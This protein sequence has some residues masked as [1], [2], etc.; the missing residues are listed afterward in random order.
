MS[1]IT[2]DFAQLLAIEKIGVTTY[3]SRNLPL[4]FGN[5]VPIS[6]G[7]FLLGVAVNVASQTIPSEFHV[8][9]V[10]GCFLAAATITTQLICS[11]ESVRDTKSFLTREVRVSQAERDGKQR[12]CQIVL[13]DFHRRE[14][15]F[16]TYS[17]PPTR[18]YSSLQNCIPS[19]EIRNVLVAKGTI[20]T[21]EAKLYDQ[22]VGSTLLRFFDQRPCPESMS[23]QTLAGVGKNVLTTQEQLPISSRTSAE[24]VKNKVPLASR[25]EKVSGLAF[26]MDTA[27][28]FIPLVHSHRFLDEVG[29]CASLDFAM[30]IFD[31]DASL[32]DWHL[33]EMQTVCAA[34]GLTYSESRL[35]DSKGMLVAS[36]T[37]HCILREKQATVAR[38]VREVGP[39]I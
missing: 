16:L 7:G 13:V 35:W 22:F 27:L 32:N 8:S 37:Q 18:T 26:F 30:R 6:Y 10:V 23:A 38:S 28:S 4:T 3:V 25:A 12:L 11:V 39:S 24:W 15:A 14:P 20:S 2:S 19:P 36:M 1:S 17:S 5:N 21:G 31:E 33:R 34:G 9:S 29:P